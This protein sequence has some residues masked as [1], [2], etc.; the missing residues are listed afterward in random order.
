[1]FKINLGNRYGCYFVLFLKFSVNLKLFQVFKKEYLIEKLEN[2]KGLMSTIFLKKY[3]LKCKEKNDA[4]DLSKP[5][6]LYSAKN[7]L[8]CMQNF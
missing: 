4:M 3:C 2:K 5:V 1:M 7:E 8:E 6:E